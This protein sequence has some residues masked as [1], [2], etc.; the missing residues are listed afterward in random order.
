MEKKV[1]VIQNMSVN[2]DLPQCDLP[3]NVFTRA[4]NFVTI[5][6]KLTATKESVSAPKLSKRGSW[7][8]IPNSDLFLNIVSGQRNNQHYFLVS[9]LQSDYVFDGASWLAITSTDKDSSSVNSRHR[10]LWTTCKLGFNILVNNSEFFPEYWSGSFGE[11]LKALPFSPT[12]TFKSKNI[13]CKAMRSHKNFLFALNLTEQGVEYPYS[14]RWSHPADENGLPFSWDEL[15]LSTLASKE[16]VGGDFGVIIDGLSLRDSF[17]IYTERAIHVLDYTG[18][19]FVFRRR[20]LTSSYGALSQNCIAEAENV[21]YVITASDIII[22]DG[23]SVQS[24]LTSRLKT[25]FSNISQKNYKNSFAVVNQYKTE[26]WFCYPEGDYIW[27]S[28]AIVYNYTTKQFGLCRLASYSHGLGSMSSICFGIMI[29]NAYPWDDLDSYFSTWDTWSLPIDSSQNFQGIGYV[30]EPAM[31][32]VATFTDV[33]DNTNVPLKTDLFCI[34]PEYS[35]IEQL[36]G[37][38]ASGNSSEG[39]VSNLVTFYEK[40]NWA[41]DGQLQVKT[42]TRVY[43]KV[44]AIPTTPVAFGTAYLFV[45]AHDFNGSAIRWNDPILFNP[46]TDR[47][48]D[49]RATGELLAIRFE[50]QGY[51]EVEFYGYDVE[52]TLNGVR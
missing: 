15:D 6:S 37:R 51:D 47:K 24:L 8:P 23:T 22:N 5:N 32:G 31:P 36:D 2:L 35:N 16:S 9:G 50:F 41:L 28:A 21:H 11:L 3:D 14:Y 29:P 25:I 1:A 18:D 17:C 48:I 19:E 43:P 13:K 26:I 40:T 34:G 49:V 52:Y 42:I 4:I 38:R 44:S 46:L 12:A 27:P 45:G 39:S 33:W 7:A 10:N 20:L 30:G